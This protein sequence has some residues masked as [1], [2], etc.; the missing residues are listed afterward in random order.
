MT[1][2]D[3]PLLEYKLF[4]LQLI[5]PITFWVPTYN[6]LSL[7][8]MV[9]D[10]LRSWTLT[11][12]QSHGR[13]SWTPMTGQVDFKDKWYKKCETY[14]DFEKFE[15]QCFPSDTWERSLWD[16]A[17]QRRVWPGLPDNLK[18]LTDYYFS[19]CKC[20]LIRSFRET[21]FDITVARCVL[22]LNT[23]HR[24]VKYLPIICSKQKLSN[25]CQLYAQQYKLY[26]NNPYP[27]RSWQFWLWQ[28]ALPTWGNAWA[29]WSSLPASRKFPNTFS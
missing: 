19:L 4:H 17:L 21:Q 7:F 1:I 10:S 16:K 2:L 5:L 11:Q 6:F 25:I 18:I 24:I 26:Y 3:N 8:S 29:R 12:A 23:Q 28:R 13:E 27:V 14:R 15:C 22:S 20:M 9:A